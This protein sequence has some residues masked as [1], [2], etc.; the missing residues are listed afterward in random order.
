MAGVEPNAM[1]VAG[2]G[3]H[4]EIVRHSE[5]SIVISNHPR[6]S[7]FPALVDEP[8]QMS[9]ECDRASIAHPR[10]SKTNDEAAEDASWDAGGVSALFDLQFDNRPRQQPMAGLNQ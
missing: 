7:R 1:P 9:I 8:R 5:V 4:V 2:R 6:G 10:R 3:S